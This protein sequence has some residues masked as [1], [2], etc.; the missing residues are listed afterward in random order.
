[1]SRRFHT[2]EWDLLPELAFR[3]RP[4]GG[5]TLEGGKGGGSAPAP[6]PNIGIAQ[7]ELSALAKEQWEEFKTSIYPD[8]KAAA[9]KQEERAQGLYDVTSATM[10]KQ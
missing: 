3:L 9:A 4:G 2:T 6:D 5:M 1:M 7:R 8:L 10:K